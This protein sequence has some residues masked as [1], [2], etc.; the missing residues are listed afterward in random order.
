VRARRKVVNYFAALRHVEK[1]AAKKRIDPEDV[2]R[3]HRIVA[4]EVMEQGVRGA[5]A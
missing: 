1:Q 5:T 2:L 4:G 3:L